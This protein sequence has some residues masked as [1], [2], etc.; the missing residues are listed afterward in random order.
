MDTIIGTPVPLYEQVKSQTG[1][2]CDT[3]QSIT[4]DMGVDVF[5]VENPPRYDPTPSDPAAMKQKLNKYSNSLLSTTLGLTPRVF[6]VEQGSLARSSARARSDLYQSDGVHL[7][8]KGLYYHTSNLITAMQ[9]WYEDTKHSEE[10]ERRGSNGHPSSP[11]Q[12]DRG[13]DTGYRPQ[14]SRDNDRGQGRRQYSRDRG[15]RNR[16]Q[17]SGGGGGFRRDNRDNRD[18]YQPT[19]PRRTR[20]GYR[21]E[22]DDDHPGYGH[23]RGGNGR[24]NRY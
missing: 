14:R 18:R 13:R 19:G 16:D 8:T 10:V 2:L 9:E 6:I 24:R 12:G 4:Q 3:A 5:L 7:T 11:G 21:Q 15:D 20:G 17:Q 22:W 23:S 1:L